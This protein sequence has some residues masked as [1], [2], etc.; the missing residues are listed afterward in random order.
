MLG[1]G[2]RR[3][4]SVLEMGY[5]YES[6]RQLREQLQARWDREAAVEEL[7]QAT[8]ITEV[9]VLN[10]LIDCG[11]R[12]ESLHV[13]TLVPLVHV[14]WANGYLER[15]ERETILQ[16]AQEYGLN[17]EA[18]G[19]KILTGWLKTRP[20]ASLVKTWKD[21]IA[22]I[23]M[24]VSGD[25]FEALKDSTIVRAMAV[26]DSAGGYFG[27]GAVSKAEQSAIDELK[28]AFDM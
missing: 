7:Q 22:A 13:L 25:A 3:H 5:A 9:E 16:T 20:D 19:F 23:R 12:A 21:Y 28:A 14:A 17:P 11:V 1:D 4:S 26:A 10:E 2:L 18:Y 24:V 27:I 8:Q 15:G 6:D